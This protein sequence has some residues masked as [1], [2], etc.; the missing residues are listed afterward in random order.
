MAQQALAADLRCIE[1]AQQQD[2]PLLLALSAKHAVDMVLDLVGSP[3]HAIVNLDPL[4]AA[5]AA[6][7]LAE[8]AVKRCK[9]L[10][11]E[12]WVAGLSK[13]SL[14]QTANEARVGELAV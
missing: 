12:R 1:L 3:Y 10:L 8:P 4:R 7:P 11:P 14:E 9:R 5:L 2:S 6:L 13:E